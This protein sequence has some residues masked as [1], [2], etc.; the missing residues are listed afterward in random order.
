M[1]DEKYYSCKSMTAIVGKKYKENEEEVEDKENKDEKNKIGPL[2]TID[3]YIIKETIGKGT[4]STV[5]LGENIKTKEKVAI[6]ILNK[7]K[8]NLILKY[9]L[10]YFSFY[11]ISP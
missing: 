2:K 11:L 6:K 9:K 4:F 8:I 3:D 5:K 7:E 10:F 1:T